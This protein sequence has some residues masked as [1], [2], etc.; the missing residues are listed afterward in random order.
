MDE[1]SE[2]IQKSGE[3]RLSVNLQQ[4]TAQFLSIQATAKEIL[5]KCE[6]SVSDHQLYNDKYKQCSDFIAVTQ[7][8]YDE[9]REIS[10]ANTHSEL[11]V[12]FAMMQELISQQPNA[13]SLVI[14]VVE[15]GEKVYPLTTLEGREEI[16]LNI[17][18]LQQTV[19]LLYDNIVSTSRLLQVK[20]NSWSGFEESSEKLKVWL[21]QMEKK[22]SNEIELHTTLDEKRHQLQVYREI[23]HDVQNHQLEIINISDILDNLSETNEVVEK[24]ITDIK[25]QYKNIQQ[26]TQ[27]YVDQYE[28]IVMNHQQYCKSVMDTQEFIDANHNTIDLWGDLEVER[29]SLHNNLERLKVLKTTL[30]DE[31]NRVDEIRVLGHKVIPGTIENG[32]VNI[33]SQID[34]SQQEWEG[35]MSTIQSTID[36]IENKLQYWNE[37]ESLRDQCIGWLREVDTNL[38][39]VDLKSTAAEKEEQLLVLKACQGEIRAKELEIDEVTERAQILYKGMSGSRNVQISELVLKYQQILHKVKDLNTRW[40]QYVTNHQEFDS[41]ITELTNW[42]SGIKEKLAYCSDLSSTSQKDLEAKVLIIQDLLLLKDEGCV[43]VQTIVELA[44]NVLPNTAPPGHEAI[45]NSLTNIQSDWSELALKMID[46]KASLDDSINQWSGLLEQFQNFN[47]TVEWMETTYEDLSK[48]Q[49]TMSEK[50]AHLERIRNV[51][52]KVRIEKVEIDQL[53]QKAGE[54][55]ASGQQTQAAYQAKNILDKFGDLNDKIC[56]LLS[57]REEEYRDHRVYKEAYDDL[58]SWISR[59]RDKYPAIKQSSLGDKIAIENALAPL[60][61]MLNK[62]TQGE[63]LLEHLNHTGEVVLASTSPNGQEIIRIDIQE[64]KNSFEKLFSEISNEKKALENTLLHWR[65]YKEE[66]ERLSEWLQ[67]IDIIV[68]NHKLSL[69]PNTEEKN[70]KITDMNSILKRLEDGQNDVDKFNK[71]AQGLLSSHLDTYINNQ[72]R[73]LNTRYQ[74]QV[75]IAKDVLKKVETNYMQHKEYDENLQKTREWI[76]NAKDLISVSGESSSNTTKDQLLQKLEKIQNLIRNREE[77]QSLVYTTINNSD[78]IMRNTRSDGKEII[79]NQIKELQNDWD[80]IVK[81]MS[82][83]K[84]HLE[85]NLLQWSDYSSSYNSLQQWITEREAKLQQV[86]E[87]KVANSKR[88]QP[89]L[90]SGLNERKANLRQTNNIVQDIVSFEP[91]IQSVASKASDLQQAAPAS[92]ISS[93]Y[94]TLSKHAKDVYDKQKETIDKHQA[95]IDVSSEFVQWLRNAKDN[96]SKCSESTGDKESLSNKITQLKI[97]QNEVDD[98]KLKLEKVL[99]QGEIACKISES[100][101]REIIE[102]ELAFLQEEFDNYCD[103]L[104]VTK[105]SLELGVVKW[106]EYDELYTDAIDW[107]NKT[108]ILVQTFNKLQNN[109]EEKRNVLEQFQGHLQTLFDWQSELDKLNMHSQTLLEICADTRI[110]NAVTQ[111]TTKYN[112]LL[113]LAKEVMRRL[114]LHYQEHQQQ[115]SLYEECQDW[116]ERT[117]NK[118]NECIEIPNKLNEIQIK[119]NT[120]KS[121]RTSLEQGQNKLRY[122]LELKEKV[123]MNTEV[124]G[125]VKIQEDT[126]NLKVEYDNLLVDITD[127]RQKLASR[128]SQ[129][130]EINKFYKIL[131]EWLNDIEGKVQLEDNLMDDLSEKKALLEKFRSFQRDINNHKEIITKINSKLEENTEVDKNNFSDGHNRFIF[132]EKNVQKNIDYLLSNVGIHEKYKHALNEIYDWIRKTKMNIQQCVDCHGEKQKTIEKY[133]SLKEIDQSMPEGKILMENAV[134]L[135]KNVIQ[136]SG[137]EGVDGI[138]EEVKQ[139]KYDWNELDKL[140]KEAH[141]VLNKCIA[142]WNDFTSKS[143]SITKWI[144]KNSAIIKI[145]LEKDNKTPEDLQR[146]KQFCEEISAGKSKVEDLNDCCELLMEQSTCAI[147]RNRTVEIQG[148]YSTL[149]IAAQGK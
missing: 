90:T 65:D 78:K 5:K 117:R 60:E 68:K 96:L 8:K 6:Q 94:E 126:D 67:Q 77:G 18:E 146:A 85:T 82:T 58:V 16:R 12:K 106:T 80:R 2:L 42:L 57:E 130:E 11:S 49:A 91:M 19:E 30:S 102:E 45:N 7:A 100:S 122:L 35:L 63:L 75:N 109:L 87:Q 15:L 71:N 88:G 59:A 26:K 70:K 123:I 103:S 24:E 145:E 36:G 74:V 135:S 83:A 55:L 97:L 37:Y 101:D 105:H 129:L 118:L 51:E 17:Q 39:A 44:Q 120:V 1:S 89:G 72:L 34:Y 104:Q 124:N 142:T 43:K 13:T 140:S 25:V 64:L 9:C 66:Y 69:H 62:Q 10:A 29:I 148:N 98:G 133:T 115:S 14:S 144:D 143:D 56:K 81:K 33:L 121:I 127:I 132:V 54:M 137:S 99:E 79:I 40:Q 48:Y 128:L 20:L 139:L 27:K 3:S 138:K 28:V 110:S 147:V 108:E 136:T 125:A 92:E 134:E 95:L 93:K 141:N 46:I 4:I 38:H 52:E 76:N 119:M 23:F 86:C 22:L 32:Q 149:L 50:R 47:K 131:I 114:E 61:A 116:L 73:H 84:V 53:K 107:L 41:Q 111:L 113:G 21:K 112:A 31:V